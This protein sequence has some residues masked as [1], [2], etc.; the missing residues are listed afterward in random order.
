MAKHTIAVGRL[1]V[2]GNHRQE[3]GNL[4]VEIAV[5]TLTD[6]EVKKH[7]A[8]VLHIPISQTPTPVARNKL[9][10]AARQQDVDYLLMVDDDM[11][12]AQGFFKTAFVHLLKHKP[13]AIGVPYV[14]G[15]I[16]NQVQVF[17]FQSPNNDTQKS[18]RLEHVPREDAARR[19][20]IEQIANIGTGAIMYNMAVFD[21]FE[22][23]HGH[24]N[25]FDYTYSPDHTEVV[26]TEDCYF[27]RHLYFADVPLFVSWDHW[28]QHIKPVAL[29]KPYVLARKDIEQVYLSQAESLLRSCDS[30]GKN[31]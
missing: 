23:V 25:F 20:G 24:C 21:R 17:E 13:C 30:D 29:D 22:E 18:F 3:I 4:L 31:H 5:T 1:V 8:D 2:G 28:A 9:V 10:K 6:P 11:S 19:K 14:C 15:G 16:H 27:H 26:E 7:V 12:V